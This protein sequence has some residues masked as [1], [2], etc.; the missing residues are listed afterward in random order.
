VT[1]RDACIIASHC[2]NSC[3]L[4]EEY[5]ALRVNPLD[6]FTAWIEFEI[7]GYKHYSF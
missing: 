5:V 1:A 2:Q 6:R 7:N 3:N 4:V